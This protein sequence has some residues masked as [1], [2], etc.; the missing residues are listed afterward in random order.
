MKSLPNEMYGVPLTKHG[1]LDAL[2]FNENIPLPTLSDNDVLIEV[3]AEIC[4]AQQDFE[5]KKHIGKM[6]LT[7]G[8]NKSK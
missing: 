4:Q 6:V 1:D 8:E 5:K 2:T 3:R 7:V